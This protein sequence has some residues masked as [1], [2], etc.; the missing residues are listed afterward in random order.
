MSSQNTK[1]ISLHEAAKMTD[2]SQEYISLLCRRGKIKGEKLGRNWFTTKEWINNYVNKIKESKEIK[3]N[4]TDKNE[5]EVV[6]V[7]IENKTGK[8]NG[9]AMDITDKRNEENKGKTIETSL[10]SFLSTKKMMF[11]TVIFSIIVSGFVFVQYGMKQDLILGVL[12]SVSQTMQKKIISLNGSFDNLSGSFNNVKNESVKFS[13]RKIL[14]LNGGLDEFKNDTIN[15]VGNFKNSL[16]IVNNRLNSSFSGVFKTEGTDYKSVP[17]ISYDKSNFAIARSILQYAS[18]EIISLSNSLNVIKSESNKLVAS[19]IA[20]NDSD[21]AIPELRETD[22]NIISSGINNGIATL[23]PVARN[24]IIVIASLSNYQNE[25]ISLSDSL[26]VIRNESVKYADKKI[27]QISNYKNYIFGETRGRVAGVS[28]EDPEAPSRKLTLLE[29]VGII[30]NEIGDYLFDIFGTT[31]TKIVQIPE[32]RTAQPSSS[33]NSI[34][35]LQDRVDKLEQEIKDKEIITITKT[36][37]GEQGD[38]GEQGPAGLVGPAGPAGEQGPIGLAGPTGPTGAEGSGNVTVIQSSPVNTNTWSGSNVFSGFGSFE[39]LGVAYDLSA[40]RSFGVGGDATLGG[41]SSD[42][43]TVNAASTFN[44]PVNL[45]NAATLTTG[46]GQITF[47]GDV[48]VTGDLTITGAQTYSGAASF[49]ANST[50]AAL[51]VN[52]QGTGNMVQFQDDGVD[53]FVLADGGQITIAG[54]IDGASGLDITGVTTLGDGGT[55]DYATF[56]AVGNLTFVGAANLIEKA[57]GALTINTTGQDLTISTTTSGDINITSAGAISLSSG[58]T[59]A[60]TVDSDSGVLT[61]GAGTNEITNTDTD[62]ALLINPNGT[63]AVQFHA[64][65][66]YMNSTGD[67]V[68]GGRITFENAEY[69]SNETDD[70]ILFQGSGGTDDTD[71]TFNLDGSQ[72]IIYSATD[73]SIGINDDLQFIGAQTI[74]SSA[75]DLTIDSFANIV[76]ADTTVQYSSG[77]STFDIYSNSGATTLTINNSDGTQV[78]HL[79]LGDGSLYTGGVERLTVTGAL[80]NITGYSQ[81]SGDFTI[82]GT[83]N[84]LFSTSGTITQS[85]TGQVS[86]AGNL[87]A[88]NGLDVTNANLTVGGT[89]F[90][91]ASATGNIT[92][93]AGQGLDTTASGILNI[94]NTTATT[95]NVGNTAATTLAIGAGGALTR[96]INVGTGSGADTI[97]I[98]TGGGADI[99]AIGNATGT[100]QLTSNGGLNVSTAGVLT[101]VSGIATSG[102]YTQTGTGAN[103]FTGTSTFSNATYSALF[104]GGNVGIGDTTPDYALEIL[105]TTTPQLAISNDDGNDYATFD[106]STAGL[107]TITTV[108]QAAAAGHIALMPDGNVGIG[109]ATPLSKL[110]IGNGTTNNS[111]DSQILISRLVD[112]SIAGNG[113]AFSDSSNVSRSGSIGYNSFDARIDISG[114]NNFDHYAGFQA[115]P[116]YNSSGTMTNY[117][118]L[119][120]GPTVSGGTISNSYGVYVANPSGAGTVTNNYG[121]YIPSLTKGS[122][123]NYAIY[124]AASTNSYFGGDV[125]VGGTLTVTGATTLTGGLSLGADL[126]GNGYYAVDLQNIGDGQSAGSGYKFDGVNDYVNCG[127]GNSLDITDAITVSAWIKPNTIAGDHDIVG[128]VNYGAGLGWRIYQSANAIVAQAKYGSTWD[129]TLQ[130]SAV[131]IHEWNHVLFTYDGA[132]TKIY[133]NGGVP[134]IEAHTGTIAFTPVDLQVGVSTGSP[135]YWFNG[136]IDGVKI[137]NRA[138]TATEIKQA[139]SGAA[140]DYA[141]IGANATLIVPSDDCSADLT[142]AWTDVNGALTFDTDHYV[143]TVTTGASVATYTDEAALTVGKRYRA[144]VQAKDGTG[145]GSTVR[146]NALTNADVVIE[147]GTGITVAAG[148]ATASV[149]WVATETNNKVQVEIVAGTV[150]DG[151]TVLFDEIETNQIGAV[152]NLAKDGMTENYWYDKSG[153]N[154]DGTVEGVTLINREIHPK[155]VGGDSTTQDLILQTTTGVGAAGADMHFL[156]GNNGATEAMTILNDGK[157]GI[158]D[159]SPDA[160]LDIDSTSTT[161]GDFLI[162]NTGVGTTGTVAGITANSVTGGDLLTIDGNALTTGAAIKVASTGTGL[163]SGSLLNISSA[164]T[165]AVATNGIVS[166]TATGNYTSTSNVGLLSVAA[167]STT[168]GTVQNIQANALTTGVGLRVA[169]TGTGLTSGS[170]LSVS[171][172][173]TGAVATNGIVS[174]VATGAYTSTSNIG[175]LT[176]QAN[177]TLTGTIQRIEGNALTS[178]TALSIAS[179]STAFTGNLA[180]L[181]L[182][183]SNAA[184]TGSVLSLTNSGALNTGSAL[185]ITNT[186]TG[187]GLFIDQNGEAVALNID[188]EVTTAHGMT[189]AADILTTGYGASITSVSNNLTTGRMLSLDWSPTSATATGDLFRI[190]IGSGGTVGNLLNVTDNGSSLFS[191]SETAI[192]SALPHSFTAVGDVSMA[193]D[194]LFTNQ[195]ASYIKSNA[196]LYLEAGESF[197]SNDLTFKTYNQGSV[198][199]DTAVTT[200]NAFDILGSTLTSGNGI[201]FTG[202]T[203]TG[204]TGN[205]MSLTSDIGSAGKMISLAPDFSG[206]AVTGYGIY[207]AATD[208]TANANTDYSYYSD[209]T[210][211]G[212]AAKT[213]TGIYSTVSSASTTADTL[214]ALDLAISATGAITTG[215]RTIYGS[216][217]QPASTAASS[218]TQA[219]N[220]YGSY[221]APSSTL[222]TAG[223]TNV[224]GEYITSTATHNADV[225]TVNQYGLYVANGTSSTSGTSTKYGLYVEEPTGADSNYAAVFAGGNVGIGDTTPESKLDVEVANNGNVVGMIV[226]Q[227]D[228][229]NNPNAA[230][231]INAGTGN[232]L[233]IDQNGNGIALNID[234]EA[235]TVDIINMDLENT[236]GTL[237][238]INM[239]TVT[240]AGALTGF[241]LD[242][243]TGVTS[244]TQT[245]RGFDISLPT[246]DA[247]G[248]RTALYIDGGHATATNYGIDFA[249]TALDADIYKSAAAALTVK[250][251]NQNIVLDAGTASVNVAPSSTLAADTNALDITG[252]LNATPTGAIEGVD[253]NITSAGSAAQTQAA[254]DVNLA[255]G[256]TGA[257]NT[258][259]INLGNAAVGTGSNYGL[260]SALSQSTAGTN[261]AGYFSATNAGAGEGYALIT[262]SGNVGIGTTTPTDKL[263]VRSDSDGAN[264]AL[265]RLENLYAAAVGTGGSVDFYAMRTSTGTTQFTSLESVVTSIDDSN[266]SGKLNMKVASNGSLV[267][268]IEVGNPNVVINR[269]LEVNVAGN[270]GISYDLNFLNTGTTQIT[271][272]GPLVISAGDSN[273]NENLTITTGSNTVG[274]DSGVSTGSSTVTL[275]DTTKSS[276]WTADEWIGGT[277]TIIGGAGAGQV[278]KI[279]DN[280]TTTITVADWTGTDLDVTVAGSIYHLAYARGGDIIANIQNSDIVYGGFKVAG[281]DD[282][283][284]I[285]RISPD[286][287][288]EIGGS[289][290]GGSDLVV[291]QNITLTGGNLTVGQLSAPGTPTCTQEGTTGAIVY[292]FKITALNDNGETTASTQC[293]VADGHATID[294]DNY[295]QITW[296]PVDGATKY[297][298]YG[299][300]GAA[301]TEVLDNDPM[302]IAPTTS[303][304]VDDESYSATALPTANTTGGRIA[305]NT[306]VDGTNDRRLETLDTGNPQLRLTQTNDSV[307]ADFEVSSLGDLTVSLYPSTTGNDIILNQPAGT[308]GANLW[309]CLGTSCQ[310]GITLTTGG[311]LV[312]ETDIYIGESVVFAPQS[313]APGSPTE[314]TVYFDDNDKQLKLYDNNEWVDLVPDYHNQ[315]TH[316]PDGYIPVPGDAKYGTT[317]GFCVM[318]YEAKSCVNATVS[319]NCSG[320]TK[321]DGSGDPEANEFAASYPENKPWITIPQDVAADDLDAQLA[322]E[323]IGTGYH[324]MTNA[325]WMTIARNIERTTINDMDG[326]DSLQLAGGHNDNNDFGNAGNSVATIAGADPVVSSCDLT[327]N[328]E[329]A[330]NDYTATCQIRGTGADGSLDADEKGFYDTGDVWATAYSAGGQNKSQLRTHVL[331]NG[332]VIWDMS[333]NVWEWTD[334]T[335]DC[336]DQP[337]DGSAGQ[338]WLEFTALT[339]YGWMSYS[340][341]RPSDNTLNSGNGVGRIYSDAGDTGTRAFRRGGNWTDTSRAGVFALDLSTAPTNTGTSIGFRCVR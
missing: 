83:G 122:A 251:N 193:Y 137:Y 9:M 239:S 162:T 209:L 253:V 324:L 109:T 99:I 87:N 117:Y 215:T 294:A 335:I 212:N 57:D 21:E 84:I 240:L 171:S 56:S 25:I 273:H 323:R 94:G 27:A 126:D 322:C 20:R 11:A 115:N 4:K 145:A 146:I 280:T 208:A 216:R 132:N 16:A 245:V 14:V 153:N 262:E 325:E 156:V 15:R 93:A 44:G 181:T 295:I 173:T 211:T 243:T 195:T 6:L 210:L 71:L 10:D 297:Q 61:L 194:L 155:I 133:V 277:V 104:T 105:S 291:K 63:G 327:K 189:I 7:K 154:N 121:I 157:V 276:V 80:A 41:D 306:T 270:T 70:Y 249:S 131:N 43:L 91:V 116:N 221:L 271:S 98:G 142:A 205:V 227:S 320:G 182:S 127:N 201:R 73:T 248:T 186:G 164:T 199:V 299:C 144:T 97:N 23:L 179:S 206:S 302:I 288:V 337:H 37:K 74:S 230:N 34:I 246:D 341:I 219:L 113:H 321:S 128:K 279:T 33:S 229:T 149:E 28:T 197:E 54:N 92:V 260:Y 217:S 64:T 3:E 141:D 313:S 228:T 317:G 17:V 95:V 36:L 307:Y 106:V 287:D 333:G 304:V 255:A 50:A 192:T 19:V 48:D 13:E 274:G 135:Q 81:T 46:T 35:Q 174:L 40:G 311:N 258:F 168:A 101:G 316:C 236:Q 301:C 82:A 254:L 224:Y 5:E 235:T 67:L 339:D 59:N 338:E 47:G 303:Y 223:T 198:V 331:S 68:L 1:Y 136:S 2:Y 31:E 167:N 24:D 18:N 312:V 169:S 196:P 329:D 107:L 202:S 112:D 283:G 143:Y 159:A 103:T 183:G 332:E 289:G 278:Q 30:L 282:G 66:F 22:Y 247:A 250:A 234:S 330:A 76:I 218:G 310:A 78:A 8:M 42:T 160:K 293:Q 259:G 114:S 124:T 244:G 328:M 220:L 110:H 96:A 336:G 309:V 148:Y 272:E 125:E 286:G 165:G 200:G 58:G 238:D 26:D 55:T 172:A 85:G 340:T 138:L 185:N 170:L 123:N 77:S 296:D 204:V 119:Y 315:P 308:T 151:Q 147:N 29:S 69:V 140:V 12:D 60:L 161:G 284:Y 264:V 62:T 290:F 187:N 237:F 190:N 38:S 265:L 232:G 203:S 79:D 292:E 163:T 86:F 32:R 188:T 298:V 334:D 72:P 266:Y 267:T 120:T 318:K 256:Y 139:Y 242:F 305:I 166:L 75:G 102:S 134:T 88:I 191:V 118:G 176:V 257:S 51:A 268:M 129:S 177:S 100:F 65:S 108:D 300:E 89:N 275:I 184:N 152:L 49:T 207:Q 214:A 319:T 180:D 213:G 281:I 53:S 314:G 111:V 39:S 225:G 175:L 233:L 269:P 130:A 226:T 158:G 261:V 231:I 241:D 150:S 45:S 326:D 222:A 178:G 285:F 90:S 252:T 52:Q 263:T